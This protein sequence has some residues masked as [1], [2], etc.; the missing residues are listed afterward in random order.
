[1]DEWALQK[2]RLAA[3]NLHLMGTLLYCKV[4]YVVV[5]LVAKSASLDQDQTIAIAKDQGPRTKKQ[6]ANCQHS[7]ACI[8][9]H[10]GPSAG[11]SSPSHPTLF[12]WLELVA[13]YTIEQ[14]AIWRWLAVRTSGLCSKLLRALLWY[15]GENKR[16]ADIV[17]VLYLNEI[18]V[19]ELR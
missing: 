9:P 14:S 11:S 1:M 12:G 3:K 16:T 18:P 13:N 17:R 15:F 6:R 19:E 10:F 7:S 2:A 8:L 5:V 4:L